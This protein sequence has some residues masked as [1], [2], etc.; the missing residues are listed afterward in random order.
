MKSF[1]IFS[2]KIILGAFFFILVFFTLVSFSYSNKVEINLTTGEIRRIHILPLRCY[3]VVPIES[4]F[5]EGDGAHRLDKWVPYSGYNP[6]ATSCYIYGKLS[7][8]IRT[9]RTCRESEIPLKTKDLI[10]NRWLLIWN[11]TEKEKGKNVLIY[12][13]IFENYLL[14]LLLKKETI[15]AEDV[16]VCFRKTMNEY[17]RNSTRLHGENSQ[18]F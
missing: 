7:S 17:Y 12:G 13:D 9:M 5:C 3:I 15:L 14:K 18:K 10:S 1:Q 2:W 6:T 11:E 8:Q 16:E 4:P